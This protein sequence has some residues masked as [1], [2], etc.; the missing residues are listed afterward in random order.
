MNFK[1]RIVK[2]DYRQ[3]SNHPRNAYSATI[4]FECGHTRYCKGSEVPK[5]DWA[6]CKDCSKEHDREVEECNP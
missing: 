1:R 2:V 6:Y 4:T 5:G 3:G